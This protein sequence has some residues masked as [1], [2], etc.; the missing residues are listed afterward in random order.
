MKLVWSA[1]FRRAVRWLARRKPDSLDALEVVLPQ[2]ENDPRH[3]SLRTHKLK[4]ELRECFACSVGYDCRI[5]FEFQR[6]SKTKETEIL[7]LT[8]GTHDEVY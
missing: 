6:N 4:G 1:R 2:L 7:L 8:V 5:V 3:P